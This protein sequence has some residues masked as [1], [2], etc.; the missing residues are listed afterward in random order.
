M[1]PVSAR[2]SLT[3]NFISND[4]PK[5]EA[6]HWNNKAKQG[7]KLSNPKK[8]INDQDVV[9]PSVLSPDACAV[10]EE[11]EAPL[12]FSEVSGRGVPGLSPS[13]ASIE[14]SMFWV[15]IYCSFQTYHDAEMCF[16]GDEEEVDCFLYP[17][18]SAGGI[19][20]MYI[21]QRAE[22]DLVG[23]V[24]RG[25]MQALEGWVGR[26]CTSVLESPKSHLCRHRAAA[27][28]HRDLRLGNEVSR[29]LTVHFFLC[30]PI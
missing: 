29:L 30:C 15:E 5:R 11:Y 12:S 10:P 19:V 9:C 8:I 13:V 21:L 27:E 16:P 26:F 6:A 22:A 1:L 4:A 23:S 28:R 25:G 24:Q 18:I 7:M 20:A 3:I 2:I 14:V 17:Y